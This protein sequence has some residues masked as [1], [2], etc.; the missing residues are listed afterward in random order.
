MKDAMTE[1]SSHSGDN[2]TTGTAETDT[3][4]IR[5]RAKTPEQKALRRQ[6]ILDAA[7]Q[8]FADSAFDKVNLADIAQ[9]VGI[10][11]AALYRYFRSKEL[12]FLALY[13]QQMEALVTSAE[14]LPSAPPK[15]Q[16]AADACVAIIDQ[17]PLFCR[18]NA[19][20]HSVLEQNLTVE[21]AKTFKQ[22]L[23]P[24]MARF[25]SKISEWLAVSIADAIALL[26]HIQA[27]MIGCW[28]ISH[29]SETTRQAL[30]DPRFSLFRVDFR[31]TFQQHL[32][33]LIAGYI[34]NCHGINDKP[35]TE[36]TL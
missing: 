11:K 17:N 14:A 22:A 21:E 36:N 30:L 9:S 23:L 18:L 26:H 5:Q 1:Q 7:A 8:H 29:P 31:S 33:W 3:P 6:Q 24:L 16:S 12:L 10:T 15:D 19:I 27:T 35:H 13:L 28:H 34:S 20:L 32:R 2:S 25:A 4:Q